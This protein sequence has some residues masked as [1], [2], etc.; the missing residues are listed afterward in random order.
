[1]VRLEVWSS[2]HLRLA[3]GKADFITSRQGRQPAL[4]WGRARNMLSE[5]DKQQKTPTCLTKKLSRQSRPASSKG[6]F[7]QS[8]LSKD[9][10]VQTYSVTESG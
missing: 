1:M 7:Q 5:V 3:R 8:R 10:A 4:L 9:R 2:V 6:L